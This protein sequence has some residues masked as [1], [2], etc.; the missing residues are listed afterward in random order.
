MAPSFFIRPSLFIRLVSWLE[1]L[2]LSHSR[3]SAAIADS[4]VLWRV[5]R[6][7][8]G[9]HGSG[10]SNYA[11]DTLIIIRTIPGH[12]ENLK[13]VLD[14]FSA[15]T[16]LTI[17]FHKSTF[18]P[19]KVDN[20][21]ALSMAAAFGCTVSTFPQTYLGLPLSPYKL[22]LSDFAPI[23]SKSDM[24]LSGWRGRCLPIGGHLL[25][26]NSVLTSMLSHAMSAG[27][28]PAGV[29]EAIDKRRRAFL[30]TREETCNGGQCKVAWE[31]VCVP[32]KNGGLGVV[33]LPAQNSAL[34]S[35]F[36]TKIHSGSSAPWVSWFQRMYGWNGDHDLGDPHRLD[37][38]VC[39][40]IIAGIAPF[41]SIS[42]VLL[43]D[44]SST[45]FWFD[46][47][48]GDQT[49]CDR[50]P[51][52]FSHSIRPNI[53]VSLALS[54][55]LRDSLG[56]RLTMA[57]AA[58]LR[59][60]SSELSLVR[61][62]IDVPDLRNGRLTNKK[63]SNKSFY[64]NSFRHLQVDEVANRVWRSAA[65]LKYFDPGTVSSFADWLEKCDTF[66]ETTINTAIAWNI[67]KRRN[68]RTFN[69]VLENYSIV[70]NR[71]TCLKSETVI[72]VS[73]FCKRVM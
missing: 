61:V 51:A 4:G 23:M 58:D 12:V 31:D 48:L 5:K 69:G 53:N 73:H 57:A 21:S 70:S 18:V 36:L 45:A 41:R 35:K 72:G 10:L 67:W 1:I 40:D 25:L 63:L 14:D 20:A 65:P 46:L 30:W 54:L 42:K 15:A 50:F 17:N 19:I 38:P 29:V 11:D 59:A 62:R 32:K 44:G 55:G 39:K 52:L 34:L 37:T 13:K 47:W 68:T 6:A 16:G 66:V 3:S 43:G 24:R 2:D 22:R 60:L 27:L 56:P 64:A 8:G 71:E 26:V 9:I 28:L 33:S 49:L 7:R